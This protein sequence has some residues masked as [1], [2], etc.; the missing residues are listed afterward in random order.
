MLSS[1]HV[2]SLVMFTKPYEMSNS[3][4]F[5][6]QVKKLDILKYQGLQLGSTK[7]VGG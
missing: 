3:L 6:L 2:L 1:L 7:P 5:I 4:S